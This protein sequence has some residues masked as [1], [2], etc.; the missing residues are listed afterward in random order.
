MCI[1]QRRR[2]QRRIGAPAQPN[3]IPDESLWVMFESA[4]PLQL[5]AWARETPLVDAGFLQIF[6]GMRH[7]FDPTKP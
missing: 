4:L 1:E 5:T 2:V 3:R 7:R 6:E